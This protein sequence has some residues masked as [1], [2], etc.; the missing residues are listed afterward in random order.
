MEPLLLH[1]N[2]SITHTFQFG[3][4]LPVGVTVVGVVVTAAP[5]TQAGGTLTG[6]DYLVRLSGAVHGETYQVNARATLS[7]G[8]QVSRTVAIRGFAGV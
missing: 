5:L 1:P 7:S 6:S 8:D 3:G 2:E 4:D